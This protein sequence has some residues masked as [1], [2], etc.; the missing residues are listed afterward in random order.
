MQCLLLVVQNN[1][2]KFRRR[3]A[4]KNHCAELR[5]PANPKDKEAFDEA[6]RDIFI[7]KTLREIERKDVSTA[8][9]DC[10]RV[11]RDFHEDLTVHRVT[12]EKARWYTHMHTLHA[13]DKYMERREKD[14]RESRRSRRDYQ[15]YLDLVTVLSWHGACSGNLLVLVR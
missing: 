14:G 13:R 8:W 2:L 10:A 11:R 5:M 9:L 6:G 12:S 4:L 3:Q 1:N 7:P 15:R